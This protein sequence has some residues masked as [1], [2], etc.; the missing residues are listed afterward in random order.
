MLFNDVISVT[1][2]TLHQP[3]VGSLPEAVGRKL[4]GLLQ[5][6]FFLCGAGAQRGLRPPHS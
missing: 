3:L 4:P 2:V 1:Q 6:Y 5:V